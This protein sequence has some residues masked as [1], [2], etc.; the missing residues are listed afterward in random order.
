MVWHQF[1]VITTGFE[2]HELGSES[3]KPKP[4]RVRSG[5]SLATSSRSATFDHL[6]LYLSFRSLNF[7]TLAQRPD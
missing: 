4:Q 7:F 5:T 1:I 6:Y 2:A 3:F